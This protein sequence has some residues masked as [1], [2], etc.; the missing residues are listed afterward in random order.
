M[1]NPP[2]LEFFDE[3][4]SP[5]HG[6]AV[7]LKLDWTGFGK[8]AFLVEVIEELGVVDDELPVEV[9]GDF[10]ADQFDDDGIP[11]ANRFVGVDARFAA[12]SALGIIP[13]SAGAF[14]GTV[15][16]AAAGFGGVPE[17]HLGNAA[18]VDSAVSLGIEFEFE[19]EFEVGVVFLGGEEKS[20]AIVVDDAVF[21]LPVFGDVFEALFLFSGQFFIGEGEVFSGVFGAS[22][23]PAGE[24]FS[25][26]GRSES[27][28]DACEKWADQK[29]DSKQYRF[30]VVK[31]HLFV[32]KFIRKLGKSAILATH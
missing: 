2:V 18:E 14:F 12:G 11:L 21:D 4:I 26:E 9:N 15:P 3:D 32:A 7:R 29:G 8:G 19:P 13:E 6:S 17:L 31:I 1:V 27:L 10:F 30:H 28:G 22:T 23:P 24:V 5:L 20:V 16:P 25:I